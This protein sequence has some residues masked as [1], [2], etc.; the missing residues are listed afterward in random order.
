MAAKRGKTQARRNTGSSG[1]MP[2][3]AWLL[4]GIVLTVALVMAVQ[5]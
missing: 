1:G 5:R 2:G 3:W 4:L